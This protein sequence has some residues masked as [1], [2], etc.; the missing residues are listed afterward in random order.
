RFC[1]AMIAIRNEISQVESGDIDADDNPL[2]NAPHTL[3]DVTE[4]S[5][6]HPYTRDVAAFPA[7]GQRTEKYWPPVG[8]IDQV[9]GDRHL[10]CACPP[11]EAYMESAE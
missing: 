7:P 11:L 1:D 10:T 8:R 5:W 6:T 4:T 2:R 9:Y 3:A